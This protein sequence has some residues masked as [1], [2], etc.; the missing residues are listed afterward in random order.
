MYKMFL[1][2]IILFAS[3]SCAAQKTK[4]LSEAELSDLA[5]NFN[6]DN[7]EFKKFRPAPIEEKFTVEQTSAIS[8][9]GAE[10][11]S[12]IVPVKENPKAETKNRPSI[13][14]GKKWPPKNDS[15]ADTTSTT[16]AISPS[17]VQPTAVAAV[18]IPTSNSADTTGSGGQF[19]ELDRHSEIFWGKFQQYFS[20]K[21]IQVIKIKY[22]AITVG[23]ITLK[24]LPDMRIGNVDVHHFR[25]EFKS[26]RYYEML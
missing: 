15:K 12:S 7:E 4:P 26:E 9:K 21:E 17:V 13:S 2:L 1:I 18:I 14:K 8:I 10:T 20:P 11:A 22:L 5:K 24:T 6:I 23:H 16:N 19:D 3:I 25:G